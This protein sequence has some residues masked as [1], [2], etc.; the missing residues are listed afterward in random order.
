MRPDRPLP[1]GEAFAG[2]V[3]VV[4]DDPSVRRALVR[5]LAALGIEA[6]AHATGVD[7]LASRRLHDVDCLLLDVHMPGLNGLEVLEEVRDAATKLPVV[8]MT[9]RY[10]PAF[11]DRSL[12]AGASAFLRKPFDEGD[13]ISAIERATGRR[14]R[15]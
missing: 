14:C 3:A 4:D 7:F 13:L 9:G 12:A 15:D 5:L 10:D 8:L 2:V 1:E 6:E 11:A